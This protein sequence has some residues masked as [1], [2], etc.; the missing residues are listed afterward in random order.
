MKL[1]NKDFL[2]AIF[3]KEFNQVHVTD[4]I[5][6]PL[7]IPN[8]EHLIAWG[9]GSFKRY[10]FHP[11][12]ETN[13]YFTISLFHKDST[14]KSRRR[15]ALFKSTPVIVLDDVKEKLSMEE[16]SKLPEP[17]Y[18][19]ETSPGSE[20]WGYI[21][22]TPCTERGVVENLLDGLVANGLAPEGRDP[23]MKGVTRYVRLP[24]GFN[25]KQSKMIDGKPF[26]CRMLKWEPFI[27]VGIEELAKPFGVDLNRPRREQRVDGAA[28]VPDHPLLHTGLN[29]K[30]V[31]SE[32][33]FD[34]TCPWV[35]EHTDEVDNGAA[36]FTNEDG[37]GGF[38]CHHGACQ[39]RTLKDL[40]KYLENKTPGF[41]TRYKEWQ[42]KHLM[43]DVINDLSTPVDNSVDNQTA[44]YESNKNQ[45]QNNDEDT[46][47]DILNQIKKIPP[48]T[49]HSREIV[50][51][52]L[53]LIDTLPEIEKIYYHQEVC[54]IMTWTKQEFAKI[55]KDMRISWYEK[56]VTEFYQN[57]IFV[58]E[59]NRFYD[60][61]TKIFYTPEA[62][63]N[64]FAH[65]D[66]EAK[67]QA[68]LNGKV[69][70]VDK[71]DFAPK[72][73]RVFERNDIIYGNTW[74]ASKEFIGSPGDCSPWLEHWEQLGWSQ[75]KKHMLQFM[76]YTILNPQKKINH[77][78]LLGS[79]EGT[80]KDFLLHPLL[81]AMGDY[82]SVIDG[83]ELL[84]GFNEYLLSTK[85]LHINET[86]LGDH[87]QA[88]E[89]STKLKPLAASPP[90]TLRI[91]QKGIS[92]IKV[93][94]IVNLTM[95][96]NSQMPVKLNGPSRRFYA[97]WSDLN[98]RD[99]QEEMLP[100]WNDYWNKKWSWMFNGGVDHCVWYLR[101][102]VDLKDF[103]PGEAPKMTEFL[104]NIRESSKSPAQQTIE[105]FIENRVGAFVND[106]VTA[107]DAYNTLKAGLPTMENFIYVDTK[108]FTPTK[109][110]R[111]MK[112]ITGCTQLRARGEQDM[113][114]WVVRN[115]EKYEKLS[116]ADL[117]Q[118]YSNQKNVGVK[119]R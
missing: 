105:A 62:F 21:L 35:D 52:F 18:I 85:Y 6:D 36:I 108:W 48:G 76:A 55:L 61:N 102:C 26:K 106:L 5:Y 103:N 77:M 92:P 34:I 43:G 118:E 81:K 104:R 33:R 119:L 39:G 51:R 7:K 90:E 20:Q 2:Q 57:I 60:Y 68:L 15:K 50:T 8:R 47:N 95:T 79:A 65:E 107:H 64:S 94:N 22:N 40:L 12:A 32:G 114:V 31:R 1:S 28:N 78:L 53:K 42:F 111:V 99:G 14:G 70:K 71:M 67:K 3:G 38:E 72:S 56:E 45:V 88:M 44:L 116:L 11:F 74:S 112:D 115:K 30:E 59:Q 73:P 96:T 13:Q 29:I 4:F 23:G 19:M 101:N 69:T 110:S 58:K 91:N 46:I 83:H 54:D 24:E 66:S 87:H 37:S 9:G 27:T 117:Y 41:I 10:Q 84:S 49:K 93:Q 97:V 86:E 89:V 113:R 109:V 16:V 82:G 17:T 63:Q 100:E 80:G 75:N 98:V 25:T